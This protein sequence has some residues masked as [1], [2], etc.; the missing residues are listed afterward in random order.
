MIMTSIFYIRHAE[1]DWTV[2][3][4][5]SR[6]LTAKGLKDCQLVTEFLQDKN[7]SVVLSS[8]YKRAVDTVSPFAKG[9]GLDVQLIEDFRERAISSVWIDDFAEFVS[10]QWED[11]SYKLADGESLGEVQRRN[12]AALKEAVRQYKDKNIVIGGHGTALSTLINYYDD[13][14]GH[15]EFETMGRIFPW[16]VRMDF[17]DNGFVKMEKINL[18]DA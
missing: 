4:D 11:F 9:R 1:P 7:I 2:H 13:T 3:D 5:Q 12:V 10:K 14:Y 15:K 6:P 16:V 8:P 18:F 17:D